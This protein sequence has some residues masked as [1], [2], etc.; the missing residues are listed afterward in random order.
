LGE[1]SAVDPEVDKE[2]LVL[3]AVLAEADRVVDW[4]AEA[5]DAAAPEVEVDAAEIRK[6]GAVLIMA[7]SPASATAGGNSPPTPARRSSR[8]KTP[9]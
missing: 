8:Y 9:R 5:A 4:V 3:A 2:D 7:S 6:P 1:D